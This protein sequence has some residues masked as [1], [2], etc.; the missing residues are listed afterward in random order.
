MEECIKNFKNL[1]LKN[2][3]TMLEKNWKQNK[4]FQIL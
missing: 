3:D 2:Y 1:A 4:P